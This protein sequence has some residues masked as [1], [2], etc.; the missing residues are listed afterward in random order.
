[1]GNVYFIT[2]FPGF[3]SKALIKEIF[4]TNLPVEKIILFVLPSMK[5]KAK[6]DIKELSISEKIT[7]DHF[8]LIFGDITKSQLAITDTE[9]AELRNTVTHVY[10]L[11]AIYDLAVKKKIA[12]Q[13]NVQGT[14]NVNEWVKE[15]RK[16]K[17]Y[18]YFSTA[19]VSGTRQ[20]RIFEK[21]L[22]MNQSFK[23][24]YEKTK[25]EAEVLVRSQMDEVPTTIIRPGIVRGHSV[26]GETTKFDGPYFMLHLLDRFKHFPVVPFLANGK[27]EANFVP[28]DYVIKATVFL[29][30]N[31]NGAGKTYHL[32]D[33]APFTMAQVY[34][35]L[36][37][38]YT[39]KEPKGK[40]PLPLSSASLSFSFIRK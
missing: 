6:Q 30:H 15:L 12:E 33:P 17:R 9:Q 31:E 13:V 1:M 21:E 25:Y 8:K 35:M 4:Q 18:T 29:S 16:L 24:H 34:E 3:L 22:E 5:E 2:G 7:I 27:A 32:T 20:G 39:G 37:M 23:N 28:V 10:H 19:Y 38:E 40:I 11:A 14:K 36:A 26:T